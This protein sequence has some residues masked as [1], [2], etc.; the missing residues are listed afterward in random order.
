M[1]STALA[2]SGTDLKVSKEANEKGGL[3]VLLTYLPKDARTERQIFGRTGRKGLPGSMRQILCQE[4]VEEQLEQKVESEDNIKTLRDA[5]EAQRVESL[6]RQLEEIL[7]KQSLFNLFCEKKREF[8]KEFS[9]S[10]IKEAEEGF[11]KYELRKLVGE[12]KG[13][14]LDYH[15][16][17]DALKESWALWLAENAKAIAQEGRSEGVTSTLETF[18]EQ[19]IKCLREG[20]TENFY[21]HIAHAM[22]RSH[23]FECERKNR[24]IFSKSF[25]AEAWAKIEKNTSQPHHRYLSAARYNYAQAVIQSKSANYV[26]RAIEEKDLT[27]H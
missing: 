10:E 6:K 5:V 18:L 21:Q 7:F 15:P 19:K 14:K 13:R 2:S 20:K 11:S 26:G 16:A 12:L 25:V 8:A 1:I 23:L 27:M 9:V 17:M 4:E 22:G 24:D 3:H